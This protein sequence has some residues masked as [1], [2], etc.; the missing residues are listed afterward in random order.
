MTLPVPELIGFGGDDRIFPGSAWNF[1]WQPAEQKKISSFLC[2]ALKRAEAGFTSIPQT[3][4][5]ALVEDKV[6]RGSCL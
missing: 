5:F 2:D 6:A 1:A 3:G 4:S